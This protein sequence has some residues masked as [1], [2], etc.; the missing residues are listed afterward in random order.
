MLKNKEW[1]AF[2]DRIEE[3]FDLDV[4]GWVGDG[5]VKGEER[6]L[7]GKAEHSPRNIPARSLLPDSFLPVDQSHLSSL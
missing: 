7:L 4:E 5:P 2:G 6:G 1:V 3:I